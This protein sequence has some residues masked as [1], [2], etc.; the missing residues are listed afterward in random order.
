M[1]KIEKKGRIKG[2]YTKGK[3]KYFMPNSL[4]TDVQKELLVPV[5]FDEVISREREK[6]WRRKTRS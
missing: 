2:H 3:A 6:R 4:E 5:N 1:M